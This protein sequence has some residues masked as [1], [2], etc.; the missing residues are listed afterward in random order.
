MATATSRRMEARV[1]VALMMAVVMADP[2]GLP[3]VS[4][5][6]GGM[7]DPATSLVVVSVVAMLGEFEALSLKV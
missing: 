3:V 4:S 6:P 5:S 1:P 2:A 7:V